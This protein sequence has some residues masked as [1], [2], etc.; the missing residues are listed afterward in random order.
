MREEKRGCRERSSGGRLPSGQGLKSDYSARATRGYKKLQ[1][2]P[3]FRAEGSRSRKFRVHEVFAELLQVV[4]QA[5]RGRV[6][7]YSSYFMLKGHSMAIQFRPNR[8]AG[9]KAVWTVLL[10]VKRP[11]S[12]SVLVPKTAVSGLVMGPGD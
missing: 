5:S 12:W 11:V 7:S 9:S 2:S 10:T 8:R 6:F 3:R 4:A 1:V